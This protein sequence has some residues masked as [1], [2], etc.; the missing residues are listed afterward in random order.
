VICIR[1]GDLGFKLYIR[2]TL[3]FPASAKTIREAIRLYGFWRALKKR[4]RIL[5]GT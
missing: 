2:V 5:Y 4:F 1:R 3:P